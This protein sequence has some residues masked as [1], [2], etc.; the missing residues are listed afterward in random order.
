MTRADDVA[1]LRPHMAFS[2]GVVLLVRE[3]D[4]AAAR[5]VL[6]TSADAD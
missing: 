4:E 5:E 6:T 3:E 2:Q 1:G